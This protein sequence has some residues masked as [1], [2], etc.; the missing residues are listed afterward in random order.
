M[1]SSLAT[2]HHDDDAV[3]TTDAHHVRTTGAHEH[4]HHH[5]RSTEDAA[6]VEVPHDSETVRAVDAVGDAPPAR[7]AKG[8]TGA[9]SLSQRGRQSKP[10]G[11]AV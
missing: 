7:C 6:R 4:E 2:Q 1:S 5:S 3:R 8:N 9:A 11:A 10:A